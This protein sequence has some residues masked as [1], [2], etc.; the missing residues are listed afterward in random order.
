MFLSLEGVSSR[1][2]YI[3]TLRA[4]ASLSKLSSESNIPYLGYR[5]VENIFCKA[6]N[7]ENLSRGDCSADAAKN[8]IGIGIKTF[9]EGNGRS[10]QKVA[11][12]NKDMALFRDK[13]DKEIV[14]VVA[15]LRNER[16]EATKRIHG[17]KQIVYHCVVRSEG[18]IKVF[19][20]PMDL[21]DIDNIVGI[22]RS[23]SNTISFK[24]A[25]NEYSIN[26]SKSTLYKRFYT[27]KILLE[28]DVSIISDPYEIILN[29]LHKNSSKLEFESIQKDKEHIFLPLYSD[30]GERHVPQKSGLNQWNAGGRVRSYDE[31]YIPIPSWIHKEFNGFFPGRDDVFDLIL[32]DGNNLKAKIC[33]QGCKALMTNPNQSLGKWILRQVMNLK[34]G[35]LLTYDNLERLGLDSVV[36]YKEGDKKYSINFTSLGSYDEFMSNVLE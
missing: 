6:F 16:I 29:L 34:N 3:A 21:I 5:E 23:G 9:I 30:R 8:K 11:E 7:A 27:E 1:S 28:A 36:V 32:P 26:I 19:E 22:K 12:F 15:N 17:L 35:E 18:K 2:E 14:R 33:Q 13:S 20:C 4:M 31:V 25:T 24:D 10:L